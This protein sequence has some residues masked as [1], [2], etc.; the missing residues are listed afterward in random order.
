MDW[1]K[2]VDKYYKGNAELKDILVRH[3]M[4]VAQ[5]AL[6]IVAAHPELGADRDFVYEA[7]SYT[8]LRAHETSV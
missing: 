4:S 1:E 2:I 3:S 6:R 8:H 7:V 5:K